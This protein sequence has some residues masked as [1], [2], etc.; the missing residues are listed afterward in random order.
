MSV[1]VPH[2]AAGVARAVGGEVKPTPWERAAP[3][4]LTAARVVLAIAFF[5]VLAPFK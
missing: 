3:N 2:S 1:P 4:L 5:A